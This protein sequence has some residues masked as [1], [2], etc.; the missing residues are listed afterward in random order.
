MQSL[1]AGMPK[2]L[3]K[4]GG[5]PVIF[6]QIDSLRTQAITRI[7]VVAGHLS[8]ILAS[9]LEDEFGSQIAVVVEP[10][11]L[12]TGGSLSLVR[13]HLSAHNIVLSGD[14]VFEV[15]F[16]RL[17]RFHREKFADITLTT[18][19]NSHPLDSDLVVI[20]GQTQQ[21]K[22]ILTRP[23][24]EEFR[25][26]N[27]VN[28]SI[29][30][31]RS[32]IWDTIADGVEANFERDIVAANLRAG[33][34]VFSYRT[35]EYIADMGTPQRWERVERDLAAGLNQ[36]RAL[37]KGQR[38]VFIDRDGV[39]NLFKGDITRPEQVQLLPDVAAG[40]K[41]LNGSPYLAILV[42][43]QPH[44]AKGFCTVDDLIEVNKELETQ[45]GNDGAKLDDI[46]MCIHHPETG[47]FGED[48]ELKIDCECRKPKAGMI[49]AAKEKYNIDLSSSFLI[50]DSPADILAGKRA[51]LK[52]ILLGTA[53]DASLERED[54]EPDYRLGDFLA[55]VQMIVSQPPHLGEQI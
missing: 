35:S 53:L 30:V 44:A 38:A 10:R 1:G 18:H 27:L 20:E 17:L 47:H 21:I 24:P 4:V 37:T 19:P 16:A 55:A 40:L 32:S 49:L 12:G 6:R 26:A 33:K 25:Y 39:L 5:R 43:N 2:P 22:A 7:V 28:A 45:L 54:S 8:H 48:A 51:G 3:V 31:V 41:V 46:F 50:G 11:P 23:H 9:A 52:T 15:D 14:L 42:T 29:A 34:R 36:S 13:S